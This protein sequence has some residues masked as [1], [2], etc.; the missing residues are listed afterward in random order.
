MKV[1]DASALLHVPVVLAEMGKLVSADASISV[2]ELVCAAKE[3]KRKEN[4]N[5]GKNGSR[6]SEVRVILEMEVTKYACKSSAIVT[7]P[8]FFS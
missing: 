7:G 5:R 6:S 1:P 3:E 2:V 4:I 8:T